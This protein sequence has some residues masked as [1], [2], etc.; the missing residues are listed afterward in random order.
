MTRALLILA[1]MAQS[2]CVG[3]AIYAES[4]KVVRDGVSA[5][6]VRVAPESENGAA[7]DCVLRAM[8]QGEIVGLPNSGTLD[9]PARAD[10][11]VRGVLARPEASGCI[12]AA[13]KVAG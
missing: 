8:T 2:G 9:D 10:A 11:F 13:P 12:A 5:S 7:T 6:L 1:L 3:V 4:R